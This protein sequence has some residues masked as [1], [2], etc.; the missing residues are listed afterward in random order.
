MI[1]LRWAP[2]DRC[3]VRGQ[4]GV[5][6]CVSTESACVLVGK[7]MVFAGLE[8]LELV[9]F[10]TVNSGWIQRCLFDEVA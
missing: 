1:P 5:V 3:V 8:E 4:A 10:A 9:P 6:D 7:R 2:A